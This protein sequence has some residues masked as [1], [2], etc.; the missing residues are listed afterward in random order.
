[1]LDSS[2][3]VGYVAGYKYLLHLSRYTMPRGHAINY[4]HCP[5]RE[6]CHYNDNV[7]TSIMS[8]GISGKIVVKV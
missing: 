6:N 4:L 3:L 5:C 2:K 8:A 1:M 7:K